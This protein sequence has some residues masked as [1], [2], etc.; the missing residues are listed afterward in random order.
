MA[1][2]SF[3][4]NPYQPNQASN[5]NALTGFQN[6][7][8]SQQSQA[9]MQ[10]AGAQAAGGDYEGGINSLLTSGNF[11][12]AQQLRAQLK[13]QND[14][15]AQ[16]HA[17]AYAKISNLFSVTP[18]G[19]E[20]KALAGIK[21]ALGDS[22]SGFVDKLMAMPGDQ[23][24]R[25]VTGLAQTAQQTMQ[26]RINQQNIQLNDYKIKQAQA[27]AATGGAGTFE[28][29]KDEFGRETPY[30]FNKG[31]GTLSPLMPQS[32]AAP[33]VPSAVQ[34][35]AQPAAPV[36][37]GG[38]QPVSYNPTEVLRTAE[39][40]AGAPNAPN[41]DAERAAGLRPEA[42]AGMPAGEAARVRAI[43][44]GTDTL[45]PRELGSPLGKALLDR[46][47]QYDPTFNRNDSNNR[48]AF[49]RQFIAAN[50]KTNQNSIS[51]DTLVKH[52]TKVADKADTLLPDTGLR[53][54]NA[55]S[56]DW[57]SLRTNQD[58]DAL[59]SDKNIFAGETSKVVHGGSSVEEHKATNESLN[60]N[61]GR[62]AFLNTLGD[63]VD[64]AA[65]KGAALVYNW[66]RNVPGVPFPGD[67]LSPES[68]NGL[69]KL[70]DKL[71]TLRAQANKNAPPGAPGTAVPGAAPPRIRTY[72]PATGRLN[73]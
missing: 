29:L 68:R 66:Q 71:D 46:V 63:Q 33:T 59:L 10:A 70:K 44:R 32:G 49:I 35:A 53:P 5:A 23:A 7:L 15:D 47:Y 50:G 60:I 22:N 42:L 25:V 17:D 54:L 62:T 56:N 58:L 6:L 64:M 16:D 9:S 13:A 24:R 27:E 28:K 2:F 45:L 37:P 43:Q 31:K 65:D 38:A 18:P 40:D 1:D 55:A 11:Q 69:A 19:Q 36:Q 72:N 34:P 26:D 52:G 14:E 73:P 20:M 67:I 8:N 48:Q 51:F 3:L 30:T 61:S 12:A 39:A 4:A 57:Q 41:E 21:G